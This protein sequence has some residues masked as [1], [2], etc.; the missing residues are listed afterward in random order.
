MVKSANDQ[1]SELLAHAVFERIWCVQEIALGPSV[2]IV[3]GKQTVPLDDLELQLEY[4]E[5]LMRT[6]CEVQDP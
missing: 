3:C 2:R 6:I 1:H 4:I 5:K